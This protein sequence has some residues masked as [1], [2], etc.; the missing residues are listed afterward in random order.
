MRSKGDMT[1][2]N[3]IWKDVIVRSS[4]K[5]LVNQVKSQMPQKR[6]YMTWLNCS[7]FL[8]IQLASKYLLGFGQ[9]GNVR[10]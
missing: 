2:K 6:L 3:R 5:T 1:R 10:M 8:A 9:T 7:R 4:M